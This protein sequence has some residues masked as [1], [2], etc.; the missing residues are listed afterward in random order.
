MEFTP[1]ELALK[2][3]K[4]LDAKKAAGLSVIS[5]S[6]VTELADYFV[7]TTGRSSTQVKAFADEVEFKLKQEGITPD[8]IEGHKSRTWI[9]MDYQCVVVHIFDEQA[10]EYYDLERLW[11]DGEKLDE[12]EYVTADGINEE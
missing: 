11:K 6:N 9:V 10:R 1:K 12:S 3:A 5:V 2:I 8:H 4:I 7:I